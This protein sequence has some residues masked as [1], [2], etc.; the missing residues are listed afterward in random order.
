MNLNGR[1]GGK[2]T[3]YDMNAH[4]NGQ[5]LRGRI[6]AP[7]PGQ[8][9]DLHLER[10]GNS[11]QG[12]V[13]GEYQGFDVTGDL[14]M[15]AVHVRLGGKYAGQDL[16]LDVRGPEVRGRYGGSMVGKDVHLTRQGSL[17]GGRIG[18]PHPGDGKDVH[19]EVDKD[20]PL[21][22]AAL[23]AVCAFKLL[24][25]HQKSAASASSGA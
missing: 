9:G 19:L 21:E 2:L 11:V 7:H 16:S 13:G 20:M 22:V 17:V 4:W 18:A 24:E 5:E 1:L 8:G 25:D 12:R 15:S 10:L 3:G 23:L 14:S 6:G